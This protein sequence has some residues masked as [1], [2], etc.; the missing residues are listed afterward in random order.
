MKAVSKGLI[1]ELA[2]QYEPAL[3]DGDYI[4]RSDVPWLDRFAAEGD[5]AIISGDVKMRTKHHEKLALYENGF[6]TIFFE[7]KWNDWNFFR[8]SALMLHWWEEISTKIKT[9]D[10]GTFWVVPC[11]WPARG[12][13]ELRNVSLGL[14][15]L[16][17][18]NPNKKAALR[19][20]RTQIAKQL[21]KPSDQRQS[22]LL[23]GSGAIK[24]RGG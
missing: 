18:D 20:P 4:K 11:T 1:L 9:A 7:R 14:A 13:A 19:K 12:Q 10:R 5:H 22:T 15:Q 17:K 2:K 24:L 16:L 3:T 6:V 21:A 8:K 23:D